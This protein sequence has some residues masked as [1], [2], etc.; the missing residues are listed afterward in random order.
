MCLFLFLTSLQLI[1]WVSILSVTIIAR[2]L[3]NCTLSLDHGSYVPACYFLKCKS[4]TLAQQ[5]S[6]T[7]RTL[8]YMLLYFCAPCMCI[9]FSVIFLA[10]SKLMSS[11]PSEVVQAVRMVEVELA[12]QILDG[13]I[14]LCTILFSSSS[15][16]LDKIWSAMQSC[17]STVYTKLFCLR[18]VRISQSV[19]SREPYTNTI[20]DGLPFSMIK[21]SLKI[22]LRLQFSK[23]RQR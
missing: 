13:L 5:Y 22:E 3:A 11:Q 16:Y 9:S 6:G 12:R 8:M 2:V 21:K 23:L 4:V 19:Q 17:S 18:Y 20:A 1:C 15:L 14:S 10:V 7:P